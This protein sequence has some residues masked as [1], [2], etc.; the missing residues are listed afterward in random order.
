MMM[1]AFDLTH[2]DF[3]RFCTSSP[4]SSL[5]IDRTFKLGLTVAAC[6]HLH[7][8]LEGHAY[9][10]PTLIGPLFIH[11]KDFKLTISFLSL[12]QKLSTCNVSFIFKRILLESYSNS[13]FH[14]L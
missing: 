7:L 14:H 9:K 12:F 3:S 4:V 2:T 11:F 8:T 10:H 6:S 1:L 5:G 13:I